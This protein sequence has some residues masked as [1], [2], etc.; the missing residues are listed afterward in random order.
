MS[1]SDA[2]TLYLNDKVPE[3]NRFSLFKTQLIKLMFFN[4]ENPKN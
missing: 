3:V 4:H 1:V 2:E